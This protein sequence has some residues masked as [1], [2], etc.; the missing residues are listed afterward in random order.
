MKKIR[1]HQHAV[2]TVQKLLPV[3]RQ[4]QKLKYRINFHELGTCDLVKTV[5]IQQRKA[6]LQ[7]AVYPSVPVVHRIFQQIPLRVQQAEI[8]APG[9]HAD[10]VNLPVFF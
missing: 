3:L 2:R 6:L 5:R 10:A 1:H 4:I 7:H 8:H 9:I